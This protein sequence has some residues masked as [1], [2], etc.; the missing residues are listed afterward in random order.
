M[1]SVSDV[2]KLVPSDEARIQKVVRAFWRLVNL[3]SREEKSRLVIVWLSSFTVDWK[4]VIK[5][6]MF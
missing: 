2:A 3:D 5:V 1:V 4:M 6:F